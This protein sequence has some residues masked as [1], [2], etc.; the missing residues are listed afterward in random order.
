MVVGHISNINAK[1]QTQK[2]LSA[3]QNGERALFD[4]L[5][6]FCSHFTINITSTAII[7]NPNMSPP[8]TLNDRTT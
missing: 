8:T 5:F 4:H 3:N 6:T 1:Y 2:H 7:S